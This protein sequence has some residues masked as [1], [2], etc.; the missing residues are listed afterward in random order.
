M[1]II[2]KLLI[3][4]VI[5]LTATFIT[6]WVLTPIL[7]EPVDYAFNHPNRVTPRTPSGQQTPDDRNKAVAEYGFVQNLAAQPRTVSAVALSSTADSD[8]LDS[9]K[10]GASGLWDAAKD[11]GSEIVD[12]VKEKGPGWVESA[13]DKA[14][15]LIDAGKE[16]LPEVVDKAKDGLQTAQDKVSQFRE[17]QENQFWQWEDQML[18]GGAGGSG[19]SANPA[20]ANSAN[21]P[22]TENAGTTT[23]GDI[24]VTNPSVEASAPVATPYPDNANTQAPTP[25]RV[26]IANP[27]QGNAPAQDVAPA[28]SSQLRSGLYTIDGKLYR[29]DAEVNEWTE[30]NPLPAEPEA[31]IPTE[32]ETSFSTWKLVLTSVTFSVVTGACIAAPFLALALTKKRRPKNR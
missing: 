12:T 3:L 8:W 15:D 21:I 27:D 29:Y 1:N 22:A 6:R 30:A 18:N 14:G 4:V 23:P 11:K 2:K 17:D 20:P 10:E 19:Q 32:N 31:E 9:L 26:P 5:L 28:E 25:A 7:P 13:K 24:T 16:K